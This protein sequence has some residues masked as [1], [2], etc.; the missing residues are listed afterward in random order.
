ME[1]VSILSA[2]LRQL[3][4]ELEVIGWRTERLLTIGYEFRQAAGLALSRIDIHDLERLVAR[5]CPLGTAARI[6]G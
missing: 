5:G 6:V 3:D 4:D 1:E 2:E